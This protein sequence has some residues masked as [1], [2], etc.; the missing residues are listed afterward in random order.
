[1]FEIRTILGPIFTGPDDRIIQDIRQ[2]F[3]NF[4]NADFFASPRLFEF[5]MLHCIYNVNEI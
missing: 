3:G 4:K 1:M 2:N 5:R